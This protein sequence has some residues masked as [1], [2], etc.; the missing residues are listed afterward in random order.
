MVQRCMDK[1]VN[2]EHP[3]LRAGMLEWTVAL[4]KGGVNQE[5]LFFHDG[6]KIDLDASMTVERADL[7]RGP[8]GFVG[9]KVL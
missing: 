5:P 9:G 2:K 7:S 4:R 8:H 1:Q 6:D 3:G